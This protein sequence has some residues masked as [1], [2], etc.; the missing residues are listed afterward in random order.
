MR[1]VCLRPSAPCLLASASPTPGAAARAG[2][3]RAAW[4]L[5]GGKTPCT[6]R[7][8]SIGAHRRPLIGASGAT[9]TAPGRP[10]RCTP[11]LRRCDT[12]H[13]NFHHRDTESQRV[14]IG[15]PRLSVTLCLCGES[16]SIDHPG[17]TAVARSA[18][19]TSVHLPRS[20]AADTQSPQD[21]PIRLSA[22]PA[23]P[24]VRQAAPVAVLPP[25]R[26]PRVLW[27]SARNTPADSR[28]GGASSPRRER[29][30]QDPW[31]NPTQR[32]TTAR[33]HPDRRWRPPHPG[34][35]PHAK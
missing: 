18:G 6:V 33:Q 35:R 19:A 32:D 30:N 15:R 23:P 16:S 26:T 7:P 21:R 10:V 9:A 24:P 17:L 14:E 27:G 8:G 11:P 29:P 5:P 12:D 22:R 34:T 2:R 31:H 28:A 1:A 13:R 20:D 3:C 25:L 4:H